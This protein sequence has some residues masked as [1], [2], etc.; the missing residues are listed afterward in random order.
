[1]AFL[2]F[3]SSSLEEEVIPK[4]KDCLILEIFSKTSS[5]KLELPDF[6]L[7]GLSLTVVLFLCFAS[8]YLKKSLKC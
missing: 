1:M 2:V 3:F 5:T 7:G 6:V 4:G 8:G